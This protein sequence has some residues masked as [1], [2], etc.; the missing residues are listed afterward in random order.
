[1]PSIESE[2]SSINAN[3]DAWLLKPALSVL[4]IL[5]LLI[6][7]LPPVFPALGSGLLCKYVSWLLTATSPDSCS[8]I[9]F[10]TLEDHLGHLQYPPCPHILDLFQVLLQPGSPFGVA[11]VD[12]MGPHLEGLENQAEEF[13]A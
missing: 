8:L 9:Q 5:C 10:S 6:L 11:Q 13:G 7:G 1:M 4:V 3:A 12:T 2:K